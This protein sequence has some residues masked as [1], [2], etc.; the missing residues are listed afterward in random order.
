MAGATPYDG[1]CSTSTCPGIDGFETCRRL[2]ER[3]VRT[4]ILMLTA[5]DAVE[6]RIAG[7]D[8][9]ADDYL[10]K[11]FDFGELLARLRALARRG[12]AARRPGAAR[13]ATCALDPATRRVRRG[14]DQIEL[15]TKE[16]QLLE[17]FM[18]HPGGVLSRLRPARGRLGRRLREPLQRRRR[19]RPLPAR[20]DR[21]P[22]RRSRR[23]RPSAA[24]ATGFDPRRRPRRGQGDHGVARRP[25]GGS[26]P[27]RPPWPS[28]IASTIASP[29]PMPAPVGLAEALEGPRR[30]TPSR[31]PGPSSRTASSTAPPTAPRAQ[32]DRRRARGAGALTT[33][34]SSTW[35]APV[36]V[37]GARPRRPATSTRTPRPAP[38]P[39][40]Q[41]RGARVPRAA[42]G[43]RAARARSG[44]AA[45]VGARQQRAGRRPAA[46]GGS[47][48]G[49]RRGQRR[50]AAPPASPRP[51]S[52]TLE[53]VRRTL[54]G[55][56]SSWLASA[57]TRRSA[58]PRSSSRASSSLRV[59]P[60]RPT[61]SS[62]CRDGQPL[63]DRSRSVIGG[64]RAHPLDRPQ[65]GAGATW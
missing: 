57:T 32:R 34:L 44:S 37:G 45:L 2:R 52:A 3:R 4:P 36:G 7:L 62:A 42:P 24:P 54:S 64:P 30:A 21:P 40:P 58:R 15:S 46:R 61:S 9:G 28:A 18:R 63:A 26:A 16:F 13:S 49:A 65:R 50:P 56:R 60:S 33:R 38:R 41:P 17:V 29:R 25:R 22:V 14:G 5:R 12:P 47:R 27:D 35:A 8:T 31:K 59:V 1:I 51:R 39:R 55:V 48:L 11:P 43:R 20:E 53:P 6:D 10:V 23:S 19:L